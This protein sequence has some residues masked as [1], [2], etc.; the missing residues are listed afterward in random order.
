MNYRA[1]GLLFGQANFAN[2]WCSAK[3]GGLQELDYQRLIEAFTLR[4]GVQ[5]SSS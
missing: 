5:N 4:A 2:M 1:P 3:K